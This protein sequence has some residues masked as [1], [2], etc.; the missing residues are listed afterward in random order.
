VGLPPALILA[1]WVIRVGIKDRRPSGIAGVLLAV[2]AIAIVGIYFL[3]YQ[4]PMHH[5]ESP[6]IGASLL[7][8]LMCLSTAM[9]SAGARLWPG[10]GIGILILLVFAVSLLKLSWWRD[11]G[12]RIRSGGLIL[13]LASVVAI[14]VG[15]GHFRA[16]FQAGVGFAGRYTAFSCILLCVTYLGCEIYSRKGAAPFVRALLVALMWA[17]LWPNTRQGLDHG[18]TFRYASKLL[19]RDVRAGRP[20]EEIARIHWPN[21]FPEER[22]FAQYLRM[23][24]RA[25]MAIYRHRQPP[26]GMADPAAHPSMVFLEKGSPDTG[27]GIPLDGGALGTYAHPP[28]RAVMPAP[29]GAR[30]IAVS[31][32]IQGGGRTDGVEFRIVL[33][34]GDG[35]K[36]PLWSG[37]LA[38]GG[39]G[40]ASMRIPGGIPGPLR[41]V[42]ETG[43]GPRGDPAYDWA[44]WGDV[45]FL[46]E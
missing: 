46:T 35:S 12:D 23:I 27:K 34:G 17:V 30:G 32:G 31:F 3:D 33:E 6:G 29:P 18:D 28:S 10:S 14:A 38:E 21:W 9:G 13:M 4:S 40:E 36:H 2:A 5:P 42:L 19:R 24:A 25:R 45:R 37:F 8:G 39:E 1:P 41:I 44:Y 11:R 43:V 16:G 7:E 22:Q 15:I 20:L 26:D